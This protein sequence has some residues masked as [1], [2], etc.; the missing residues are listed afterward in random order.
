MRTYADELQNLS[1]RLAVDQ[2]QVGLEVALSMV[3]PVSSQRVVA[4]SFG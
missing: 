2:Q 3:A 1:V 4:I